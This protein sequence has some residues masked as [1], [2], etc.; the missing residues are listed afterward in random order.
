MIISFI[1]IITYHV[2]RNGNEVRFRQYL[3]PG[4]KIWTSCLFNKVVKLGIA[5][6]DIITIGNKLFSGDSS[7]LM[8]DHETNLMNQLNDCDEYCFKNEMNM[9]KTF[10]LLLCSP[11]YFQ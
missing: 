11:E 2:H 8:N 1:R 4:S 7:C 9:D 10:Y 5:I 6:N 3:F